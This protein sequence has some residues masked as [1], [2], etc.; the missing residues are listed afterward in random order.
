MQDMKYID[1]RHEKH[2]RHNRPTDLVL[3]QCVVPRVDERTVVPYLV[4]RWFNIFFA[5]TR[6]HLSNNNSQNKR[7]GLRTDRDMDEPRTVSYRLCNP[8]LSIWRP[9]SVAA[10]T[11][12]FV[13]S[14]A[15]HLSQQTPD[16]TPPTHVRPARR[17][18]P[19]FFFFLSCRRIYA[20]DGL[21][22]HTYIYHTPI[23]YNKIQIRSQQPPKQH[24]GTRSQKDQM[25]EPQYY[26]PS[27]SILTVPIQPKQ[28][29]QTRLPRLLP[30]LSRQRNAK[31]IPLYPPG[32]LQGR[33]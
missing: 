1:T 8:S 7:A 33:R 32:P 19:T 12:R 20:T 17:Q 23:L 14:K 11:R 6:A 2:K 27:A 28:N 15:R 22:I 16:R 30:S 31:V 9:C 18:N 24:N 13:E 26:S 25:Y 4:V 3:G 21:H 10:H 29:L 5:G